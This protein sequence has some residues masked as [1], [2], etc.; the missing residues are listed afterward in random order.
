M[1]S[2]L[3]E[4]N[5]ETRHDNRF[6]LFW[7]Q[8][9]KRKMSL[10]GLAIV[11]LLILVALS[12][13]FLSPY[14][15]SEQNLTLETVNQPPTLD[16]WMGT[17]H[18]GRDIFTRVVYGAR[19]SLKVGII[20]EII[21]LVIGISV[22][23]LA[24]YRGGWTDSTLMR[25]TDMIFAFP[26]AL[27]AIAVMAIFED[28]TVGKII[29]VL[30]LIGWPG[31]AR[32]VR[33]QVLTTKQLEFSQAAK[34]LGGSDLRIVARHIL[35]NS[36]A[37]VLV[38]ATIGIAGNIL[39]ESWLSFLGLGVQPPIPSWGS[40][41]TDGQVYLE[42]KPW[43]CIFPGLAI[44]VT[45]MGFNLFGDGLRDALDPKLRNS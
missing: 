37:P 11:F 1:E 7:R 16:H 10:V 17:D 26:T 9:R 33:A 3:T 41:I 19:I 28:P 29:V 27:F 24:G 31:I 45:V 43:I 8:L 39:T 44:V 36:M 32:L 14:D 38:A 18:I 42:T 4:I 30:G 15:P 35:P 20:A 12:A 40:M 23:A 6:C 25:F 13:S 2:T 22:G 5:M 21:A 34:A